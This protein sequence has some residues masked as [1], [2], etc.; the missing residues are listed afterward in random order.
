VFD[1][2]AKFPSDGVLQG[3]FILQFGQYDQCLATRGPDDDDGVPRFKGKYCRVL[4]GFKA[5]RNNTDPKSEML[6]TEMK[7]A[8]DSLSQTLSGANYIS[9]FQVES[10]VKIN[11]VY[12]RDYHK[13]LGGLFRR[14]YTCLRN[15]VCARPRPA[16]L[17]E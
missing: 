2:S 5:K 16:T 10:K 14:M 11:L 8:F 7:F 1:S 17:M 4:L 3:S 6:L 12:G 9:E 15:G 13:Q